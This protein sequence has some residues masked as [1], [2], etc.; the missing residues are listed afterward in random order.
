MSD[1]MFIEY[2][3]ASQKF[4]DAKAAL[5]RYLEEDDQYNKLK[6]DVKMAKMGYEMKTQAMFTHSEIVY[7]QQMR[8]EFI[9]HKL[10][11]A[12]SSR[13]NIQ[14]KHFAN[15]AEAENE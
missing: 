3:Q 8:M 1:K 6:E 4:A 15:E 5:K 14:I 12:I 11:E 13:P 10:D 9:E 7:A 2:Y